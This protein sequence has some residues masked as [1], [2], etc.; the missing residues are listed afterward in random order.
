MASSMRPV[1]VCSL[2]PLLLACGSSAS[3]EPP[4]TAA[5]P[6]PA[7]M[8]VATSSPELSPVKTPEG[9]VALGRLSRPS[10]LVSTLAGWVSLPFDPKM[11]DALEPG[12]ATAVA[13]D[14]PIEFAVVLPSGGMTEVK[15][16]AVVSFGLNDVGTAK[17]LLEDYNGS[18][19]S[20]SSPGVW[21]GGDDAKAHCAVAAS[22]GKTQAR[23]VCGSDAKAAVDLLPYATRGLPLENLGSADLR[24]EIRAAA[25]QQK[26]AA[27]ARMGK[28]VGVPALLKQVALNDPR[29]DRPFA[30]V[31][32]ALGDELIDW[33]EDLERIS[34]E[35]Q[36]KSSPEQVEA[37]IGIDYKRHQSLIATASSKIKARMAPPGPQ[38]FELPADVTQA[39]YATPVDGKMLD[40]PTLLMNAVLDGFLAHLDVSSNLR[41]DLTRAITEV[42]AH[43]GT[44]VVAGEAPVAQ[45]T[46]KT[47]DK[48]EPI[49]AAVGCHIVGYDGPATA[50]KD[51][52]RQMGK[53]S[54]D[55]TFKKGLDK[56]FNDKLAALDADDT[57]ES[58]GKKKAVAK[59]K[60][61]NKVQKKI[62]NLVSV[63]PLAVRG[64]P[65]GSEVTQLNIELKAAESLVKDAR[66]S[67]KKAPKMPKLSADK[68]ALLIAV[69]PD[70]AKSWVVIT[71]DEKSL[72]ERANS[73]MT[74]ATGARLS[75]RSEL[76]PMRGQS[77]YRAGFMSLLGLRSYLAMALQAKGKSPKD[78]E[79]TFS[80]LP[81][82]GTTPIF[83]Q[84][85]VTGDAEHPS[86]EGKATLPRAVFDDVAAAVPTL[87]M[88]F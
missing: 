27:A 81:H 41:R 29:F 42:V 72:V 26:F 62:S 12:L 46:G 38:F 52:F 28:T 84:Y 74:G 83:Y 5:A 61:P 76:A 86:I 23:L 68:L 13:P 3:Q 8:Q 79:S 11:L 48:L 17:K 37:K 18:P 7:A 67:G 39:Y 34:I 85:V 78:A 55:P 45:A 15:P 33:F 16:E 31:A 73:V 56:L 32:H 60:E 19:L 77:A 82:H 71:A 30:D 57:A 10:G 75:T 36:V 9:L 2:I 69:V 43:P 35:L 49:A 80:T 53:L 50:M 88:N 44:M 65:A 14:A 63:K 25:L 64:M 21:V 24:V 59:A 4:K 66:P 58:E 1:L 54:Q 47:P 6:A 51:L 70:G 87:M 20:E 22:L 40:K